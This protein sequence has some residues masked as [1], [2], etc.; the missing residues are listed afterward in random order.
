MQQEAD[1]A[2]GNDVVQQVISSQ[3]QQLLASQSLQEYND[4]YTANHASTSLRHTAAAAE[5]MHML[6]PQQDQQAVKLLLDSSSLSDE[7][8]G[9][10]S[11]CST[12][13]LVVL[14]CP[15]YSAA[16]IVVAEVLHEGGLKAVCC[17]CIALLVVC[18]IQ[19]CFKQFTT[20]PLLDLHAF[21]SSDVA[22]ASVAARPCWA[23]DSK[24]NSTAHNHQQV[25]LSNRP[26]KFKRECVL[27]QS[28]RA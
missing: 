22:A 17:S 10:C 11:W 13:T 1:G 18:I 20:S 5:M 7:P 2:A 23:F 9:L 15:V 8:G 26:A 25:C 6:Q 16:C 21:V 24:R 27:L 3:V 14:L 28:S 4:S 19:R 12:C